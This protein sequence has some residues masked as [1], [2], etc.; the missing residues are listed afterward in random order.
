MK[1]LF[2][3]LFFTFFGLLSAFLLF[4][5]ALKFPTTVEVMGYVTIFGI[6]LLKIKESYV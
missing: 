1:A 4:F 5:L 6:V 3:A 2:L